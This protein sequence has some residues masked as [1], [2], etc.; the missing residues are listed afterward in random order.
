MKILN[1]LEMKK[2]GYEIYE[3]MK[4]KMKYMKKAEYEIY[5]NEKERRG[6]S[7]RL[8]FCYGNSDPPQIG[9]GIC[10]QK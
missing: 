5:E 1:A 10:C 9:L 7:A 3:N 8:K 6:S 4:M 2:H